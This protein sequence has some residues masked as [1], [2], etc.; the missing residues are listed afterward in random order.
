MKRK[1]SFELTEV[2]LNKIISV[3]YND[4]SLIDKLKVYR[5]ASKYSEVSK[6]YSSYKKI[7]D[8]VKKLREDVCPDELISSVKSN[9]ISNQK[10][11]KIFIYD[12]FSIIYNRPIISAL[13]TLMLILSIITTLIINKPVQYNYSRAEITKADQQ[14]HYALILVGKVFKQTNSTLQQEI[15][16]EKVSKPIRESIEM[17]NNL[18]Q[19]EKNEIN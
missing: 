4:A 7:C 3:A 8:E 9:T 15:L 19:G 14:A 5:A 1:K 2:F 13:T 16:K 10:K 12:L 17:V 11:N 18:I 6:I